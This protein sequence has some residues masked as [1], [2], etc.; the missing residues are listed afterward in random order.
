MRW[1]CVLVAQVFP[2]WL[3][4]M[5]KSGLS[6]MSSD[7][8]LC[9]QLSCFRRG[10][11]CSAALHV[12]NRIDRDGSDGDQNPVGGNSCFDFE[13]W[14][15]YPNLCKGI[16]SLQELLGV[17]CQTGMGLP[18]GVPHT[19]AQGTG[20][21]SDYSYAKFKSKLRR[22]RDMFQV[23]DVERLE[24]FQTFHLEWLAVF[25]SVP[26]WNPQPSNAGSFE[27][28]R[29]DPGKAPFNSIGIAADNLCSQLGMVPSSSQS[30]PFFSEFLTSFP[31]FRGVMLCT[32][33]RNRN[34]LEISV[35]ID[36]MLIP[37]PVHC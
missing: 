7:D 10:L 18:F 35:P 22:I 34:V 13:T 14:H 4:D 36:D 32:F 3:D 31:L 9:E 25:L 20:M 11:L 27:Q 1:A 29:V 26:D 30:G 12:R 23:D 16:F 19:K 37:A 28:E 17:A 5:Q 24:Q 15:K 8:S 2:Q 21:N 33:W 6:D